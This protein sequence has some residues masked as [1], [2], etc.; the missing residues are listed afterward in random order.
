MGRQLTNEVITTEVITQNIIPQER[1]AEA[2]QSNDL[3]TEH[4]PIVHQSRK[5]KERS[6]LGNNAQQDYDSTDMAL[7]SPKQGWVINNKAYMAKVACTIKYG[8]L[9]ATKA[10]CTLLQNEGA[11]QNQRRQEKTR[12]FARK[13]TQILTLGCW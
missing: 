3:I 7:Y 5:E 2:E 12:N 13:P 1:K 9:H 10:A 11:G 4:G 6:D 8:F